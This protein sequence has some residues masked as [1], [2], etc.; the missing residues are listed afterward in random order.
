WRSSRP[1]PRLSRWVPSLENLGGSLG[2]SRPP[3]ALPGLL[4]PCAAGPSVRLW[5]RCYL[6]GLPETQRGRFPPSPAGLA[7][8]LLLLQDRL[9]AWRPGGSH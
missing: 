8:E 7:E 1:V 5:R 6:R 2:G 9:R 4:L 3:I